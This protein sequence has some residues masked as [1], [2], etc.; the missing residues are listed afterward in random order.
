MSSQINNQRVAKNTI[1]LYARTLVVMVIMLYTSRVVLIKLGIEDYGIYQV[2]GGLMAMF[3]IISSSLTTSISRF[4][5]YEIGRGDIDRLREVFSTSINI[6]AGISVIVM[7]ICETLGIWFLNNQMSI[8]A[9]RLYAANWVLQCSLL[10]F[11]INLMSVPYNACIVAHE[12]MTVF[13]YISVLDA[14]L[15][16]LVCYLIT[17]TAYDKLIVFALLM[18]GVAV[19]IRLMYG[20]YCSNHFLECHY[21]RTKDKSL[22][23][24]MTGFAGWNFFSELIDIF[25]YYGVNLLINIYFGVVMNAA[26]GIA[27]QA[28]G[29]VTQFVGNFTTAIN[30]QITKSL[31]AGEKYEMFT[32]VCRGA[33]FSYFLLLF[34][35]I[36]IV[37]ET[38]FILN[39]WLEAVPDKTITFVRLAM[40]TE[41]ITVWG[42]TG[43]TACMATGDV[44]KYSIHATLVGLFVFP[45]TWTAYK[46]GFPVEMLYYSYMLYCLGL[47]I[48][49]LA[50]MKSQIGFPVSLFIRTAIQPIIITTLMSVLLPISI[51][52]LMDAGIWRFVVVLMVSILSVSIAAFLLGLT[53]HER[54]MIMNLCHS[55]L[56]HQY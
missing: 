7:M 49:R 23:K 18:L 27:N 39:F 30:P 21:M 14:I 10:V 17:L 4:I 40:I 16:L 45:L 25:N 43:Y 28:Q 41:L 29:A 15:K 54:K 44:R 33:K 52:L 35:V 31:A 3:Y 56:I 48:I 47:N 26:R 38:D 46:A 8:P 24:E 51:L 1:L 42:Y 50:V 6:Q 5:T 55:R 12:K 22:L 36:P 2:V 9:D 34:F 32:L 37:I 11:C 20:V 19:L 13:A 53:H